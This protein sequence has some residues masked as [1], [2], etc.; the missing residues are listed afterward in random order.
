[1]FYE[2]GCSQLTRPLHKQVFHAPASHHGIEAQDDGSG[3]DAQVA[4]QL[5]RFPS[6]KEIVS[7]CCICLAMTTHDELA[8]H[9]RYAQKKD[10][11]EIEKDESSTPVLP[12]HVRETPDVSQ[13]DGRTSCCQY[14][15]YP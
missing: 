3:K 11:A 9:P 2:S 4:H 10:A 1:M 6:G 8:D 7:P 13:S 14:N 15:A 5:P 12:R